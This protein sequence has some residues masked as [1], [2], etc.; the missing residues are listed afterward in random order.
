MP[1]EY[2]VGNVFLSPAK[3]IFHG[4][5]CQNTMN[6]GI[7]REMK[8]RYPE[9]YLADLKTKARDKSKLGTLT[10]ALSKS[11]NRIL[12]N[13]YTQNYYGHDKGHL[14]YDALKSSLL[15]M[16]DLLK[17]LK[18]PE[19]YMIASGRIG[20]GLAGGDWDKIAG[21]IELVFSDK[22]IHIWDLK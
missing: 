19:K 21:I 10:Y 12:I 13:L 14:D 16:K 11:D 15:E 18:V 6:S 9:A 1:I 5:N 7:A 2:H 22:T 8:Q 4:A 20:A 3:I 17:K